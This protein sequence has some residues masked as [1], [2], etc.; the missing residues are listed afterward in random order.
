M[1]KFIVLIAVAMIFLGCTPADRLS[2]AKDRKSQTTGIPRTFSVISAY[3]GDTVWTRHVENSYFNGTNNDV[4]ILDL[5]TGDKIS[6]LMTTGFMLITEE[7][8]NRTD[9]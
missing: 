5:K 7:K 1:K 6:I 9:R 8:S 4:D 3:T 2:Y